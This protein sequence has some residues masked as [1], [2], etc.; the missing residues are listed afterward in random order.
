MENTNPL[1]G[2]VT[3]VLSLIVLGSSIWVYTDAKSIGAKRG[4]LK[5]VCDMGPFGWFVVSLGIWI[6]GFPMYL[7][8]RPELKRI[9]HK[10]SLPAAPSAGRPQQALDF[11]EQ[12]RK[13]A[14]LKAEGLVSEEEFE[15]KRKQ[16]L[17]L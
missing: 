11:D 5:G 7:A 15:H 8:S 16:I 12:L 9:N 2:A 3:I 4:Q 10:A 14:K 6:I 1:V 17:G 13:L